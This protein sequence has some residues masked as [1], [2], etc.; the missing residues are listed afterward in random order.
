MDETQEI[1]E[2]KEMKEQE[3]R[4]KITF[5]D[6]LVMLLSALYVWNWVEFPGLTVSRVA[7]VAVIA[8]WWTLLVL[9]LVKR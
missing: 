7:A 4:S 5:S 2:I 1:K 8:I 3:N 6:V 9:K